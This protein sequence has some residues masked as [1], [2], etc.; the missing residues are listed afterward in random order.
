VTHSAAGEVMQL[1]LTIQRAAEA[2]CP[3]RCSLRSTDDLATEALRSHCRELRIVSAEKT[4]LK[5]RFSL[6]LSNGAHR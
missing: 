3:L 2:N 5:N 4:P 6:S 1:G